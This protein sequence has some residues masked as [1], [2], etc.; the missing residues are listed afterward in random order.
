VVLWRIFGPKKAGGRMVD[1]M[2]NKKLYD[3]RFSFMAMVT[4][5]GVNK[6]GM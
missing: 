4:L 1:K 2:H 6:Y 3:L 5:K